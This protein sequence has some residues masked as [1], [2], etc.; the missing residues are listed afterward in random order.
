MK[1]T[2]KAQG[3]KEGSELFRKL[4]GNLEKMVLKGVGDALLAEFKQR[5]YAG[6]FLPPKVSGLG[7]PLIDTGAYVSSWSVE[8]KG[9]S[10]T[11]G[12]RGAH[13]EAGMSNEALG[14]L[15]EY[16]TGRTPARPHMR[17]MAAWLTSNAKRLVE[18]ELKR[19]L[20]RP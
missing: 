18:K 2:M 4:A 20:G 9:R 8:A 16:G 7:P 3:F 12:P 11:V 5:A 19:V 17:I 13:P 1:I 10:V 6:R 14:E 15:L